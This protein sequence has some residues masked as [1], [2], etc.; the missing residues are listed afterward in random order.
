MAIPAPG[1]RGLVVHVCSWL[2]DI[3]LPCGGFKLCSSATLSCT[4]LSTVPF[5][6]F[7]LC[8]INYA[9]YNRLNA[10]ESSWLFWR[11]EWRWTRCNTMSGD[12]EVRTLHHV[13]CLLRG[14]SMRRAC[15]ASSGLHLCI[16]YSDALRLEGHAQSLLM[17]AQG[18]HQMVVDFDADIHACDCLLLPRRVCERR[19]DH[20]HWITILSFL[21]PDLSMAAEQDHSNKAHNAEIVLQNRLPHIQGN[22]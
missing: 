20:L 14:S 19:A 7:V 1:H 12:A 13:S 10:T 21:P 18:V 17:G 4:V 6:S 9:H 22:K 2:Q 15:L 8:A 5:L 16:H 11:T 3:G